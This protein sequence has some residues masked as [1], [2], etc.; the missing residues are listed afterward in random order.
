MPAPARITTMLPWPHVRCRS[1]SMIRDIILNLEHGVARDLAR[2][3][4]I[5]IAETFDAHI[6]GIAFAYAPDFPGYVTLEI[7]AENA[8][9]MIA[10]SEEAAMAAIERFEEA[11][12]RSLLSAEHRLLRT[13]GA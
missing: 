12:R 11:A 7:P 13:I 3:F 10:E 8:A 2:D 1:I 4:A 6:A 5:T 9:Q